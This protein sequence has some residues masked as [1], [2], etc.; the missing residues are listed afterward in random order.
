[1]VCNAHTHPWLRQRHNL[2]DLILPR[3]FLSCLLALH[4]RWGLGTGRRAGRGACGDPSW[5]LVARREMQLRGCSGGRAGWPGP[6][7]SAPETKNSGHVEERQAPTA[8]GM[9]HGLDS[10]VSF[11]SWKALRGRAVA[12]QGGYSSCVF[13]TDFSCDRRYDSQ[14]LLGAYVSPST[15][16]TRVNF[17]FSPEMHILGACPDQDLWDRWA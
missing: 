8:E 2:G 14:H 15:H 13:W 17:L 12:S 11:T 10:L 7:L 3:G 9:G 5:G 1:M 6:G 16:P 4:S